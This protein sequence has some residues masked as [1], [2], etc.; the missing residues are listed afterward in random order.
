MDLKHNPTT[1]VQLRRRSTPYGFQVVMT[2]DGRS[3]QLYDGTS[4]KYA[5]S[6]YWQAVHTLHFLG[7]SGRLLI[8]LTAD[9]KPYG[10][11]ST[12]LDSGKATSL[13][14]PFGQCVGW[15]TEDWFGENIYKKIIA[16]VP[17]TLGPVR[18]SK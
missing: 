13:H 4:Y 17:G 12:E 2:Q 1:E 10:S 5:L 3:L 14:I 15:A 18:L 11:F 7:L 8:S 16:T 9:G 6:A